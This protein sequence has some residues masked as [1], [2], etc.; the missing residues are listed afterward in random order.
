[1]RFLHSFSL[2]LFSDGVVVAAA[3]EN[4][5][6]ISRLVGPEGKG[7]FALLSTTV[8]LLVVVFGEALGR[9]NYDPDE[10]LGFWHDDGRGRSDCARVAD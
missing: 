4:E 9:S 10:L 8:R 5:S 3:L 2:R 1:M 6:L 7:R